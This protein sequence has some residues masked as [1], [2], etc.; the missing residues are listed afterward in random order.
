M[1]FSLKNDMVFPLI[2]LT[3]QSKY[4]NMSANVMP[5]NSPHNSKRTSI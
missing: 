3:K 1:G 5:T 2:Y 4:D